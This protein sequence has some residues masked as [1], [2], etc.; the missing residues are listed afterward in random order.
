M[1]CSYNKCENQKSPIFGDLEQNES[2][3]D[4]EENEYKNTKCSIKKGKPEMTDENEQKGKKKMNELGNKKRKMEDKSK[5]S[6]KKGLQ[7]EK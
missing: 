1:P 6:M 3:R 5:D 7:G 4:I 2:T